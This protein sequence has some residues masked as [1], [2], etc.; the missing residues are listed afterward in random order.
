MW[1]ELCAWQGHP[2][3]C[4]DQDVQKGACTTLGKHRP[5]R[6]AAGIYLVPTKVGTGARQL[7]SH[8][9]CLLPDEY[10]WAVYLTFR[11]SLSCL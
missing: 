3:V 11:A 4:G 1:D 6:S 9:P 10:P 2:D 7:A 8:V 5:A